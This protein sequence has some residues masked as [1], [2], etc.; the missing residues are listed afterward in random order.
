MD[1]SKI[2][3]IDNHC[4]LFDVAYQ[5]HN[6]ARMLNLSLNELQEEQLTNTLVYRRLLR[7]LSDTFGFEGSRKD[8]AFK[9]RELARKDYRAY[10]TKLFDDAVIDT[11][12][13]DLGYKPAQV[14]LTD[15]EDLVPSKVSYMFRIESVLDDLWKNGTGFKEAEGIFDE[16]VENAG[17]DQ[18]IVAFK[19]IIG[20]R[21][22]LQINR[23]SRSS[24]L[25]ECSEK[26]FRDYFLLRAMDAALKC[27]KPFQIHAS[28][29]ES[30]INLLHNN[31][32]MLREV[33]ED[34]AFRELSIILVHGGY[35]Y[36]FEAGYLAAM[37]ANVHLDMSEMVPLVPLGARSGLRDMMDMCPLNKLM[38]GSD[39][40]VLPE[41]HWLGA[42]FAK[43]ELGTIFDELISER[44]FEKEEAQIVALDIFYNTARRVYG[45]I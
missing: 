35:P 27:H 11:L 43:Q 30:N 25:K 23:Q 9:A 34:P 26:E 13:I 33:L 5:E 3:V 28:F 7:E 39:G 18:K 8:A 32:L 37:Y 31:P 4:H 45:L 1:F 38:Y 22:G 14:S 21:T 42:K 29:G 19:S 44:Y 12:I 16:A 24:L 17:K 40:F 6:L 41:I 10:V 36:S 15:F 20:Y 2:P